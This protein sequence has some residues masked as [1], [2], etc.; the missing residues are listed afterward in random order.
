MYLVATFVYI[1]MML[2]RISRS[3]QALQIPSF[4]QL[5]RIAIRYTIVPF[6]FI[7]CIFFVH[8]NVYITT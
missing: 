5:G 7:M 2:L 1:H 6:A 4:Y 3:I 8:E